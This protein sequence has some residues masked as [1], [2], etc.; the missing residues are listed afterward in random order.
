MKVYEDQGLILHQDPKKGPRSGGG[1]SDFQKLMDQK[2]LQTHG[3]GDTPPGLPPEP[4]FQGIQIL[5]GI[6][7]TG[8]SSAIPGKEKVIG[9]LQEALDLVDFYAGKLGDSTFSV[10][11]MV[12]LVE[13]LEERME[14]LRGMESMEGLPQ[15]LQSVVS[16]L[17]VTL[18]TEIAKFKRGDYS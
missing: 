13:S 5:R 6:Q 3:N 18:G 17:V 15:G 12:P 8:Q 10:N 4:G 11:K 7:K 14:T 9:A 1:V 16:D 2:S